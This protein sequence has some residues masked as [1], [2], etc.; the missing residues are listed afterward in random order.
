MRRRIASAVAPAA[1][2]ALA[3]CGTNAAGATTAAV[4]I[5][6]FAAASLS[7]SFTAAAPVQ[8]TGDGGTV[9]FSFAG[10]QQLVQNIIDGA[11]ADVIA[12]ADMTTMQRLVAAGLV[13]TPR[14]FARN[15]L[16]IAVAPG[17]PKHISSLADLARDDV[18]TVLAAADVPAG[19]YALVALQKAHV[20]V[21]PA[22]LELDVEGALEKVESGDADAAI[23]YVTDVAGAAG[24]V[25]GI[26]IPAQDNVV[27]AY[28]VA[29]VRPLVPTSAQQAA[30]QLRAGQALV[31]SCVS[32]AVQRELV[33]HG[34][35][36]P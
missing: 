3:G 26:P 8:Q 20:T 19:R 23:V 7:Q 24:K 10:S 12:T 27:A 29:V 11:P 32:G 1:L 6:V 35:L 9:S 22:S 2:L 16:E 5:T 18:V 25:Q 13:D 30:A 34:F 15:R 31:M 33:A 17:N 4:R 21:H 14:T 36:P 28:P